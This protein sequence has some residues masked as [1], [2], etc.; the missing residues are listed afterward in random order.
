MKLLKRL[1]PKSK[2]SE[3][4]KDELEKMHDEVILEEFRIMK[5][6]AHEHGVSF[7]TLVKFAAWEEANPDWV[8]FANA[9]LAIEE[10]IKENPL[11]CKYKKL[12]EQFY[13]KR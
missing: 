4:S 2:K 3:I 10:R 11:C 12:K 1:K 5:E 13:L 9:L 6:V 7:W 8:K